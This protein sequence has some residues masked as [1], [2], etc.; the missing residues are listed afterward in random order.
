MKRLLR[1]IVL[2]ILAAAFVFIGASWVC[3]YRLTRARQDTVGP[4]PKDFPYAIQDIRFLSSDG[5]T[6]SGWLVPTVDRK[7]AIVLLHGYGGNRNRHWR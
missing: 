7:K 6:L 2:I 5:E 4:P 3:A 1:R